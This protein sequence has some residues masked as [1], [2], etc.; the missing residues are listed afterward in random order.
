MLPNK[1]K[2]FTVPLFPYLQPGRKKTL[3]TK[4]I[5]PTDSLN[6]KKMIEEISKSTVITLDINEKPW[7]VTSV[8][9]S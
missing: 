7:S 3:P 1:V 5:R 2:M 8:Y 4:R 6:L 9:S